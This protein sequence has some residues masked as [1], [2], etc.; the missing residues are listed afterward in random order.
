MA[1]S[2]D[3][4]LINEDDSFPS[5]RNIKDSL[6]RLVQTRSFR[7]KIS[8]TYNIQRLTNKFTRSFGR[9]SFP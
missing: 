2:V 7:P 6:Q 1:T 4:N 9:E 5:R 8:T 3:T